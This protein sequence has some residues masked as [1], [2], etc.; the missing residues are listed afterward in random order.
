MNDHP[1]PS[2]I[3]ALARS[4]AP[5][6]RDGVLEHVAGCPACGE[7]MERSIA[8]VRAAEHGRKVLTFE[9]QAVPRSATLP[10]AP[11]VWW[12]RPRSSASELA[13]AEPLLAELLAQPE[14]QRPLLVHNRA[15]FHSLAVV[16]LVLEEG[17]TFCLEDPHRGG[18]MIE[19]GISVIDLLDRDYL[20][21]RLLDELRGRGCGYRANAYRIV[22]ELPAAEEGFRRA[23]ELLAG[24][25]CRLERAGLLHFHSTL[26]KV[27]NRV[28]EALEMLAEAAEIFEAEGEDGKAGR[29]YASIGN[30]LIETGD[31]EQAEQALSEALVRTD[32]AEDPRTL[33]GV[34]QSLVICLAE[35]ERFQ[36]AADLM[37]E[38]EPDY[39]RV[40]DS[41]TRLRRRWIEGKVL[42]GL[43]R[44]EEAERLL[45]GVLDEYRE[46]G[47]PLAAADISLELAMIYERQGRATELRRLAEEMTTT[48][49]SREIPRET[50]VALSFFVRAVE[51]ERATRLVIERVAGYRKRAQSDPD[52]RF[53][54]YP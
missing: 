2:L 19:L 33:V 36:E 20:G 10:A 39:E 27:Q 50:A 12:T 45:R 46:I 5:E 48:F 37:A 25:S 44:E 23:G 24:G 52:L 31:L 34:R 13:A 6:L 32:A 9:R 15:R 54:D 3:L 41:Y 18:R 17:R 4:V 30:A 42:A 7:L 14:G 40:P 49:F 22:G 8:D 35:Q 26:R 11:R 47:L 21:R 53:S 38:L 16:E 51:Q 43:G 28:P 1:D 29:V